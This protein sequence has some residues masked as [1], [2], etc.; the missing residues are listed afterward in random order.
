MRLKKRRLGLDI[1]HNRYFK[2]THVGEFLHPQCPILILLNAPTKSQHGF[3][4]LHVYLLR[5][6]S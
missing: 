4:V 2:A 5:S 6:S 3:L 1:F